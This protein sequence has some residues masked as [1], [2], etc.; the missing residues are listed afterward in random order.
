MLKYN[1]AMKLLNSTYEITLGIQAFLCDSA[2]DHF[3][4]IASYYTARKPILDELSK[5]L[6]SPEVGTLTQRQR[7][8][9]NDKIQEVITFDKQNIALIDEKVKIAKNSIKKLNSQKSL[10]IYSKS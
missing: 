3:A 2:E 1:E 4:D 8:L 7:E 5:Y 9:M 10:L 6:S